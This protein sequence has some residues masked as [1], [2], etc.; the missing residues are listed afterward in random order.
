[1]GWISIESLAIASAGQS[2]LEHG[3]RFVERMTSRFM[4]PLGVDHRGDRS[5]M[6]GDNHDADHHP[7][8]AQ[9]VGNVT[10]TIQVDQ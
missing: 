6:S 8:P 10:L 9:A 3:C 7:A 5:R 1:M 4:R 2:N